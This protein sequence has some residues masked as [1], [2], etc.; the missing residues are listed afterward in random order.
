MIFTE[1]QTCLQFFLIDVLL[2]ETIHTQFW[3]CNLVENSKNLFKVQIR[4]LW[5]MRVT[6]IPIVISTLETVLKSLERG[7]EELE[8]GR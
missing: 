8:I 6:M 5:I 3:E 2:S 7:L 4:K 1:F